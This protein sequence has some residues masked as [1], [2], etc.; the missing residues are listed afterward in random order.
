MGGGVMIME[1]G[2]YQGWVDI[3]ETK[4][5]YDT[6]ELYKGCLGTNQERCIV[7]I[8]YTACVSIKCQ[9]FW[10]ILMY[11]TGG[12]FVKIKKAI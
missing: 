12:V 8:Y 1:S 5:L 7:P 11:Y 4:L 2:M 6:C 3:F 9:E 10:L